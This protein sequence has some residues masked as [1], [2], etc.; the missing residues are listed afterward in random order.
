M[1]LFY[2]LFLYNRTFD[3]SWIARGGFPALLKQQSGHLN[4]ILFNTIFRYLQTMNY[5][6]GMRN[7]IV[8]IGGHMLLLTPFGFF[9]PRINKRFQKLA[10]FVFIT[11]VIMLMIEGLQFISM[12]GSFDVDDAL[13]NVIG[14]VIGFVFLRNPE[15]LER[16]THDRE[17][18]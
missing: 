9:L 12:S 4:L 13:L 2:V 17:I 7:I 10:F 16:T 5:A 11:T 14:A 1:S 18:S 8:N 15:N 6:T 3:L